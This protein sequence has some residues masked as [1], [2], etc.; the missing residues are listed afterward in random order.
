MVTTSPATYVDTVLKK[1]REYKIRSIVHAVRNAS[2]TG[3]EKIKKCIWH[4]YGVWYP[5]GVFA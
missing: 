2:K 1:T 4:M 3:P 5:R